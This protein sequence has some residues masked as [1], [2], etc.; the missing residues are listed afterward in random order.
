MTGKPSAIWLSYS[1]ET[2]MV[3][4]KVIWPAQHQTT[5]ACI[6]LFSLRYLSLELSELEL[7]C[8][9]QREENAF[10]TAHR[11]HQPRKISAVVPKAAFTTPPQTTA[12]KRALAD[13][14]NFWSVAP[15]TFKCEA[16]LNR[17]KRFSKKAGN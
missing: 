8:I 6:R 7:K 3:P 12:G 1:R 15:T 10:V 2:A 5:N 9:E 11:G 17:I 14:F 13:N 16:G 4:Q